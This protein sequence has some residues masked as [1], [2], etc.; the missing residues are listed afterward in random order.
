MKYA[1]LI[2]TDQTAWADM[3]PEEAAAARAESLP[4]WY[5]LFEELGKAD[6]AAIGFELEGATEAKVVRVR[7]GQTIVTDGPFAETKELIGGTFLVD[8]PDLDE[9]IRIAALVPASDYGSL[10]IRPIVDRSATGAAA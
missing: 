9:A 1:L 3:T 4:R 6:P 7:D 2:Y 10:E 8:L 5:S